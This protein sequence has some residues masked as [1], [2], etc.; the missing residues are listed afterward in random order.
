MTEH[1]NHPDKKL[2]SDEV[3]VK[4]FVS[5]SVKDWAFYTEKKIQFLKEIKKAEKYI[6]S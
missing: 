2:L 1:L 4:T 5:S 6:L 3:A